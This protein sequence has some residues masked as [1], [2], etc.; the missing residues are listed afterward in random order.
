MIRSIFVISMMLFSAWA[1]AEGSVTSGEE[2]IVLI[3]ILALVVIGVMLNNV[4]S[5]IEGA[6]KNSLEKARQQSLQNDKL[7]LEIEQLRK[8]MSS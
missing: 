1:R 5:L 7:A 4:S 3:V 2:T 6:A 8:G